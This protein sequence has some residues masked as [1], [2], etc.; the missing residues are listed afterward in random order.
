MKPAL[1][2]LFEVCARS[3]GRPNPPR[4]FDE[5]KKELEQDRIMREGVAAVCDAMQRHAD[6]WNEETTQA[7]KKDHD[8]LQVLRL[9]EEKKVYDLQELVRTLEAE[10]AELKKDSVIVE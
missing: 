3:L 10:L 6:L 2:T 9:I 4:T 8:S 5:F 1:E 7:W